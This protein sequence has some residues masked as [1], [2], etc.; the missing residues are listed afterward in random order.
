MATAFPEV[1]SN[2]DT[3]VDTSMEKIPPTFHVFMKQWLVAPYLEMK[4][5]WPKEGKHILAQFDS[6]SVYVYQAF[7]PKIAEFA[8]KNQKFGGPDFLLTR[9]SWIKTNFLWMMYRSNWAS[10]KGQERILAIQLPRQS[11]ETILSNALIPRKQKEK[12]LSKDDLKVRLQWDPDHSPSGESL[13]RRAIQ[14][15]LKGEILEQFATQWVTRIIDITPFVEEMS[16]YTKCLDQLFVAKEEIY[17]LE[18]P[19]ISKLICLETDD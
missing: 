14:L 6:D 18:D 1:E 15:G 19:V 8:V 4:K 12:G 2:E 17:P 5:M 16:A 7:N 9:M 3:I 13:P 10:K 11:F